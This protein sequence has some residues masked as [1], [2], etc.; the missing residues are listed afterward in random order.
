MRTG[1]ARTHDRL[2]DGREDVEAVAE[3]HE[4]REARAYHG[5]Q[6]VRL[7]EFARVVRR[8][9]NARERELFLEALGHASAR[10]LGRAGLQDRDRALE[11]HV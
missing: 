1:N 4:E 5:E 6:K 7:G 3:R 2:D 9:S 11:R 10:L 8:L